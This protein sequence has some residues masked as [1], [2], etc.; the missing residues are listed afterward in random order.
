MKIYFKYLLFTFII[1]PQWKSI[2]E[3]DCRLQQFC[4]QNTIFSFIDHVQAFVNLITF[5]EEFYILVTSLT[6]FRRETK[7]C[8]CIRLQLISY[9]CFYDYFYTSLSKLYMVNFVILEQCSNMLNVQ[10]CMCHY[11]FIPVSDH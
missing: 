6:R 1:L 10:T 3:T 2:C 5:K 7:C 8:I 11:S 4:Q 9:E